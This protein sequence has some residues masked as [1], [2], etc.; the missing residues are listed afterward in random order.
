MIGQ[1]WMRIDFIKPTRVT[2]LQ[3]SSV[4]SQWQVISC[5]KLWVCARFNSLRISESFQISNH[6]RSDS[7][8]WATRWSLLGR[9]LSHQNCHSIWGLSTLPK[10][11][12]FPRSAPS[13]PIY[14]PFTPRLANKD[15]NTTKPVK[16]M[17]AINCKGLM[18]FPE[19]CK[20]D[21]IGRLRLDRKVLMNH[22]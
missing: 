2:G 5:K 1:E 20:N 14:F 22:L 21:T 10:Q 11:Q 4:L 12:I 13:I 17:D 15:A 7:G 8:H 6:F 18:I 19:V 3:V 9:K 16:L